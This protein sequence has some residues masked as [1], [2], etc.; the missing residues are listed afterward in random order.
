M[1]AE[2]GGRVSFYLLR[3]DEWQGNHE[4]LVYDDLPGRTF[5]RGPRYIVI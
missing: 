2:L 3:E 1:A 5:I 4:S